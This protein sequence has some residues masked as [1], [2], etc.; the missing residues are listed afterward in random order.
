MKN[1][2][3]IFNFIFGIAM[4]IIVFIA[5]GFALATGFSFVG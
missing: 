2:Q 5:I 3:G 1:K 4:L